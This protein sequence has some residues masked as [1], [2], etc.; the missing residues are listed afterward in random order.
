MSQTNTNTNTG[1]GNTNR[2][3][4][5]GRGGQGRGG[6][7]GRGRGRGS[8]GND[9]GKTFPKHSF[10]GK[11][12]DGPL[13]KL[14]ITE[15][16]QQATQ[17]NKIIDTLPVFCA[18]KGYKFINNII[19]TNTKLVQAAFLPTYPNA[20][21]WSNTYHVQIQTVDP[22]AAADQHNVCPVVTAMQ[23]KSHVFNPN[24]QKQLLSEHD[25]KCKLK[26]GEWSKL[27]ANKRFLMSI[28]YGQCDNATRTKI[29]LGTNYETVC[30]NDE[31]INFLTILQ[32]V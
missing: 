4:N 28:I 12:K 5:A 8:C 31:L 3:H 7:G 22:T 19:W 25:I 30:A 21:L 24:L 16:R 20:T 14:T 6:S 15:G 2:N 18:D 11:M 13:S 29:A 17:Y 32:T 26:L 23:E 10:E 27:L 9:R 1:G